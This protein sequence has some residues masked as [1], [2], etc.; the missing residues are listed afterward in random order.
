MLAATGVEQVMLFD[1]RRRLRAHYVRGTLLYPRTP[2]A[3][4]I[5]FH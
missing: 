2:D 3:P 1:K 4:S 5:E